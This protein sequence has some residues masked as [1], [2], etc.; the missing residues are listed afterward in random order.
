MAKDR[1]RVADSTGITLGFIDH[2]DDGTTAVW[3]P[4][5]SCLGKTNKDG[6]FDNT[7]RVVSRSICP[8]LLIK[9]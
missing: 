2:Y 1:E 5:G 8:G 3:G 4:T 7:G 6:T 9:R